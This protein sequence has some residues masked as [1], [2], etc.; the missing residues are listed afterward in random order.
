MKLQN[1]D[2]KIVVVGGA[3]HVGLPLSLV[4]SEVGFE[5]SAL[6]INE[7]A[8]KSLNEGVL[9][10]FEKGANELLQAVIKSKRFSATSDFNVIHDSDVIIICIGTPIDIHL[11]P[12]LKN[13][14]ELIQNL[15]SYMRSG[16]LVIL[17]STIYPG[18]TN[19]ISDL[20]AEREID[21]AYCPERILQGNALKELKTL[22][23]IISG[24]SLNSVNRSKDL[25]QTFTSTIVGEVAEAEFAKLFL[26]SYRYIEFA[27]T[28][29]F[30]MIANDANLDY[31][32]IMHLMQKEYPRGTKIPKAGFS[33]GPCLLKDTL[34]VLSY[35]QNNFSLGNI[36][37]MINEGLADYVVSWL[38]NSLDLNNK[39]IGILG[40][41]FKAECDDIR[42]SLS[43]RVKKNL[44]LGGISVIASDE[45]VTVDKE[46]VPTQELLRN[47]DL[48]IIC[49]PHNYIRQL[50][51]GSK[52]VIDIWNL[53]ERGVRLSNQLSGEFN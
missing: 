39:V 44:E 18:T 6:D 53:L 3:G 48:F 36:S 19:I 29:Q 21:L 17:R 52:P 7:A 30:F 37:F 5:V 16:Q 32:K 40:M 49:T 33:A 24:K 22:P 51:F 20:L 15:K 9:P 43:Y 41:A 28:N 50:D 10:F 23:Q 26:N 42:D 34:Q 25:F 8:C 11:R 4:L 14:L 35:S 47:S 46:L 1:R 31:S 2:R 38:K 27:I 45:L 13:M 12:T